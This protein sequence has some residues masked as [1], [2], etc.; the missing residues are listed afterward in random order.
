M[1]NNNWLIVHKPLIIMVATEDFHLMLLSIFITMELP[2]KKNI[3]ISLRI[4][5]V[6]TKNQWLMDSCYM[7][8][9]TSLRMMKRVSK[10]PCLELDQLVLHF[11]L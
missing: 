10:K 9:S 4:E 6:L 5:N 8:V 1:L 7:V 3:L 11:K 2:L